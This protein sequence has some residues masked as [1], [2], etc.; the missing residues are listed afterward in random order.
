MAAKNKFNIPP[1]S[2]LSNS[3]KL[4]KMAPGEYRV[5]ADNQKA[6]N[7][8][9]LAW[10]YGRKPVRRALSEGIRIYITE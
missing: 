1:I 9:I 3:E 5:F 6:E 2:R 10:R 8:R 7:F 4:K